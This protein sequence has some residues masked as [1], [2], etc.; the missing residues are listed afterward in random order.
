MEE[1]RDEMKTCVRCDGELL[2]GQVGSL[3]P[4]VFFAKSTKFLS[5]GVGL[6]LEGWC[7]VSCG[8]VELR[9]SDR[10]RLETLARKTGG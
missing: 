5:K 7:C 9:V 10:E 1:R 6:P 3:E 4:L 2:Q 8:T